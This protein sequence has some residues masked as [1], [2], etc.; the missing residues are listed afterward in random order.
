MGRSTLGPRA[1]LLAGL[2]ASACTSDEWPPLDPPE[3]SASS[4]DAP[5]YSDYDDARLV[6]L[7]PE[8]ASIQELG[9]AIHLEALVRQLEGPP[10]PADDVSWVTEDDQFLLDTLEGDVELPPGI[11][12]LRAIARLPNGD[13]LETTV[14]DVRVQARWTGVYAGQMELNVEVDVQG[15]PLAPRCAGP[16]DM[17]VGFDGRDVAVEDGACTIDVFGQTFE[18]TY[19]IDVVVYDAGLVRGTI[20]FEFDSPFGPFAFPI[21]WAGAF[22][23]DRFSAGLQGTT[24][25]PFIG[26]ADVSGS[27]MADKVDDYVEPDR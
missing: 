9:R 21:E 7:Q 25:L 17:Q 12:D 20:D 1:L 13:R 11:H 5:D 24:E 22:Y 4:G 27:L 16:L 26:T 15:L 18:A 3:G 19:V 23:D 6:V 14:G 2:L 8:S 10:L